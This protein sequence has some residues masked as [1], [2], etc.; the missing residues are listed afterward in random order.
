[1]HRT[2]A[3]PVQ[4]EVDKRKPARK[5]CQSLSQKSKIFA[6]SLY[7]REPSP[8]AYFIKEQAAQLPL[9]FC[10]AILFCVV[11]LR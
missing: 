10:A 7:T 4:G 6:S 3:S 9:R 11:I 5:G 2:K 8:S 1:M